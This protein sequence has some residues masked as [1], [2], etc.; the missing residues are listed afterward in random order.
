MIHLLTFNLLNIWTDYYWAFAIAFGVL[1]LLVFLLIKRKPVKKIVQTPVEDEKIGAFVECYGGINNIE[2]IEL[3]GRRLKLQLENIGLVDIERFKS[4]GAT[5]IFIS[6]SQIK[7]VLPYD[8]QRLVD[9]IKF[10]KM[11]GKK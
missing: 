7:M 3:D 10:N 9:Y 4:L 6:G 1:M 8:M 11:E 5:G 2:Q